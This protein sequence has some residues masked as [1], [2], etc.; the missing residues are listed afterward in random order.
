[1][2]SCSISAGNTKRYAVEEF[3][4]TGQN[5]VRALAVAGLCLSGPTSCGQFVA[6]V[7]I[8]DLQKKYEWDFSEFFFFLSSE[9]MT[10][11]CHIFSYS[12]LSD[13][14]NASVK[15]TWVPSACTLII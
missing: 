3:L 9:N 15:T 10:S 4:Y 2:K 12:W 13:P 5:V 11:N 7:H 8:Y 1:M 14:K 6:F